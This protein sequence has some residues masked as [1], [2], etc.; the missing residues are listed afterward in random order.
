MS[1]ETIP[2]E[3]IEEFYEAI[4]KDIPEIMESYSAEQKVKRTITVPKV[5]DAVFHRV[6]RGDLLRLH[7]AEINYN[8]LL[9]GFAMIGLAT[10][11]SESVIKKLGDNVDFLNA[12]DEVRKRKVANHE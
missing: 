8:D 12:Y 7:D 2:Y 3:T 1:K 9:V 5:F 10:W 4:K 6:I 11:C